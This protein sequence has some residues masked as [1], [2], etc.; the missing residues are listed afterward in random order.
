MKISNSITWDIE[1][2]TVLEEDSFDWCGLIERCKGDGTA[3]DQL[4]LNNK[5][6]ADQ[7]AQQKAIRDKLTGA[8]DKYLN[9]DI[10]YGDE[11]VARMT[12]EFLNQNSQ[13][14]NQAGSSVMASLRARGAAG[15]ETPAGGD[16]TRGLEALQSARA[17]SESQGV[18]GIKISDLQQALAN[19]FNAASVEAGQAAQIGSNISTFSGAASNSLDQY[20]KAANTGFGNAFTTTLGTTLGKTAGAFATG[21]LTTLTGMVPGFPKPA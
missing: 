7:L 13:K 16:F 14:F 10:G 11:A 9:G 3:K 5:L 19:K 4:A 6:V 8:L 20:V 1:T 12:S 17:Q 15:G 18:A 21:G 2:G